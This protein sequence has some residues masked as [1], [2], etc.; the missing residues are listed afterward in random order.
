MSCETEVG[1]ITY[2]SEI[3]PEGSTALLR[4]FLTDAAGADLLLTDVQSV[5]LR[6]TDQVTAAIINGASARN[7]LNANGGTV[8][9]EIDPDT[10]ALRLGFRILLAPLDN[11]I[12]GTDRVQESHMALVTWGYDT[13]QVG[14][15]AAVFSVQSF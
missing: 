11:P 2:L 12:L 13:V 3:V 15:E 8:G 9:P 7:V 4:G 6:L 14:Q 1:P 5:T 10:G